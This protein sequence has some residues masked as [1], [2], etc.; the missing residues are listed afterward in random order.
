MCPVLVLIFQMNGGQ[1]S[2]KLINLPKDTQLNQ[3]QIQFQSHDLR[4]EGEKSGWHENLHPD[5][6]LPAGGRGHLQSSPPS[7]PR[8]IWLQTTK[9]SMLTSARS[10]QPHPISFGLGD[11]VMGTSVA[12]LTFLVERGAVLRKEGCGLGGAPHMSTTPTKGRERSLFAVKAVDPEMRLLR[13]IPPLPYA[14]LLAFG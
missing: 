7:R 5:L 9:R 8:P 2:E 3:T 13:F 6:F 1:S 10:C 11:A 4:G 12:V 14:R